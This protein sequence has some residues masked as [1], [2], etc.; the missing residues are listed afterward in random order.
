MHTP[1][2]IQNQN[3]NNNLTCLI[4]IFDGKPST[5]DIDMDDVL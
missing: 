1:F 5:T 3:V 4:L 2:R